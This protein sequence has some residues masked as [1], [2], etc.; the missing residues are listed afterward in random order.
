MIPCE[1]GVNYEEGTGHSLVYF[2]CTFNHRCHNSYIMFFP[3]KNNNYMFAMH[4]T[5]LK[6]IPYIGTY[7]RNYR[8]PVPIHMHL[9]RCL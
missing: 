8:T 7:W 3:P 9:G 5:L 1:R 2:L 6:F 4:A